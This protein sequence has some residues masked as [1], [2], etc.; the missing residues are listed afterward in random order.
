MKIGMKEKGIRNI[1]KEVLNMSK[2]FL[3]LAQFK[4]DA[5]TGKMGLQLLER[6][7]K[8]VED[9][10]ICPVIEVHNKFVVLKKKDGRTSQLDLDYASLVEYDGEMLKVYSIGL[11]DLTDLEKSVMDGWKKITDTEEYKEQAYRDVMTDGSSTF[12]KDKYYFE[13]SPC[14]YLYLEQNGKK[15]D[16]STGKVYDPKVKGN[17]ILKYKVFKRV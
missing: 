11:R 17:C 8:K 2:K 14:P 15:Y 6:F 1:D 9:F 7:G 4:R 12:Y 13:N 10:Y 5:G 16:Y 3:T